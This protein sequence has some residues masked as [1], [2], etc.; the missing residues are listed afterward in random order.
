MSDIG[1]T[2]RILRFFQSDLWETETI[3]TGLTL[4]E[5]QAWCSDPNTSSSTATE[6][7]AVEMTAERGPWFDGYE[8]EDPE[9]QDHLERSLHKMLK[10]IGTI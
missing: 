5:A 3:M 4:A 6:P 8:S 10:I 2:Y 1:Q 7:L 9:A